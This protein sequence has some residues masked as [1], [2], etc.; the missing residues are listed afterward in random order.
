M[1]PVTGPDSTEVARLGQG[2]WKIGEGQRPPADEAAAIRLGID[3][4]MTVIDTAELYGDGAS[5]LVVGE[6]IAG[7][8]EEVFLVTKVSPH[9]ATRSAVPAACARSLQRLGTEVIDLYLLHWRGDTPLAATVAAFEKLKAEGRIRHWGV[10]NFD[11]DDMEELL[12]VPGGNQ[13]AVNQVLYNPEHRGIEF[14]LLPWQAAQGIP[15]MAYSPL[16]QGGRLLRSKTL[17]AVAARR[18][19]TPAQAAIAWSLRHPGVSSIPKSGDPAHVRENAA[20]AG[21]A[22]TA[23]DLAEIDHAYHPPTRK[24]PLAIL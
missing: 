11:V 24:Q 13:C 3:L 2:T 18:G 23:E 20:A 22:L 15:V 21:L 6:A 14:E 17:K 12:A 8:R 10:S 7:R 16:G 1:R 5:E 9:N 4:G 19:A